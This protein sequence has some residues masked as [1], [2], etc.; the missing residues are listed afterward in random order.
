MK[1]RAALPADVPQLG[2]FGARLVRFH[3]D[4]DPGRFMVW[5]SHQQLA[6]GYGHFLETQL[7]SKDVVIMVA[8]DD[9]DKVVGYTYARLEP[10]DWNALLDKH[11]ALHDIYVEEAAR[12]GGVARMLLQATIDKLESLGAPRVVLH[13]ATQNVAAQTLFTSFGFRATM[14]EMTRGSRQD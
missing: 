14:V 13:T 3:H 1:V 10:R 9:Q 2:E 6:G 5:G 8:V 11:G 12:R 4:L 7:A